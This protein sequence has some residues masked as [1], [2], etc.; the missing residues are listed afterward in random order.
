MTNGIYETA[1]PVLHIYY[2][3]TIVE[4]WHC[5]LSVYNIDTVL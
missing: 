3:Y 1:K 5:S 4:Y 2:S